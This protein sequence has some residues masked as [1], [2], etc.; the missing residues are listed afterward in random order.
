MD[1]RSFQSPSETGIRKISALLA[2]L[3]MAYYFGTKIGQSDTRPVFGAIIIIMGVGLVL[4]LD[5]KSWYLLP[6]SSAFGIDVPISFGREFSLNELVVMLLAAHVCLMLAMRRYRLDIFKKEHFWLLCYVGWAGLVFAHNPAGLYSFGSEIVGSR[7]Y[8][9]IFLG[10][11]AVIIVSNGDISE[12]D[13][14][15]YFIITAFG[16]IFGAVRGYF[17]QT[18]EDSYASMMV[19]SNYYT[20][21]QVLA[22]P[23]LTLGLYFFSRYSIRD[24]FTLAFFKW[25]IALLVAFGV[26]LLSGKRAEVGVFLMLPIFSAILRRQWGAGL[27]V[28]VIAIG[29]PLLVAQGHGH[30]YKL[31]LV[32][33]RAISYFPGEWDEAANLGFVDE[34]RAILRK[35]ALERIKQHPILG[36]GFAFSVSNYFAERATTTEQISGNLAGGNWH[37]TWLGIGADFGIPAI[38]IWAMACISVTRICMVTARG[39]PAH[40][41]RTTLAAFLFLLCCRMF[42]RSWTSGHSSDVIYGFWIYALVF[43]LYRELKKTQ[44]NPPKTEE[45]TVGNVA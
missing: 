14:R 38:F 3:A 30:I 42:M 28:G 9:Q 39:L 2:G 7:F 26:M 27:L 43:P 13:A 25:W 44:A 1:I 18:V 23:S 35:D 20:W 11:V 5:K 6:L 45:I 34:Y 10:I 16:T 37:T 29:F 19:N 40:T 15:N 24:L 41:W 22:G 33:Q 12:K 32:A 31:P 4:F 36:N 21:H 8:F 17:T